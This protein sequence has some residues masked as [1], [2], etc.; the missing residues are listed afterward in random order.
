MP[1]RRARDGDPAM[2]DAGKYA[3]SNG[4]PWNLLPRRRQRSQPMFRGALGLLQHLGVW[5]TAAHAVPRPEE[6]R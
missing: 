6:P 2:T 1:E 5:T 4:F 3:R